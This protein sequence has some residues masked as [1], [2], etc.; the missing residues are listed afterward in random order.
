MA[1]ERWAGTPAELSARIRAL[2]LALGFDRVGICSPEPIEQSDLFA[3]WVRRGYAGDMAYLARRFEER[4]DPKSVQ[5]S[6]RSIVVLGLAYDPSVEQPGESESQAGRIAS[7]AGGEDYHDVMLPRVR[8]VATAIEALV[9][10]A[11]DS[12]CYVD[13]GPVLERQLAAR[14]GLGWQGKNTLLIDRRLGSRLFLGV[15]LCDLE[16]E[17]DQPHLDHCGTCRAC[18][19]A[20]PT[21]AF[22]EAY[23][24]DARRCISYTTIELRGDVAP[25]LRSQHG[26]WIFGC[27]VCQDVCPWNRKRGPEDLPDP[28]GLRARLRPQPQWVG[29]PLAWVLALDPASWQSA[30][31]GTALRRAKY[32]GLMRNALI[33]AGNSGDR[34]LRSAVQLFAE[35][36]D[37]LLVEHA[38]WALDR[39]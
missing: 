9:E 23:V 12:R 17:F 5:E 1:V 10:R 8:A 25:D 39:L 6:V 18:L 7:Y 24:L 2:S 37:P 34:S 35:G 33:A 16:L 13:T 4:V 22:P 19:D 21:E 28:H 26:D 3:E 30:T 29:S 31:R 14:A 27:D 32:R 20:C 38:Q 36:D 15:L 11:V